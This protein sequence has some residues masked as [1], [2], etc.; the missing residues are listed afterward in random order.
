M[1]R[2]MSGATPAPRTCVAHEKRLRT[3]VAGVGGF[4][5]YLERFGGLRPLQKLLNAKDAKEEK[6]KDAKKSEESQAHPA[7]R[8]WYLHLFGEEVVEGFDGAEFVVADVEDGVELGNKEDV[9]DFLGKVEEFELAARVADGGEAADELSETGTVEV[10]DVSEVEDDFLL[11]LGDEFADSVA[12]R[13]DF[14]AQ[15]DAAV[16]VENGDVSDLAGVDGQGH[17]SAGGNGSGWEEASQWPAERES[18]LNFG[19][20]ATG[21]DEPESGE[22]TTRELPGCEEG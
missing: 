19:S 12:E 18:W 22:R 7:D 9:V 21:L 10:V 16:D 17:D 3:M 20:R 11:V 14:V 1:L 2:S 4:G 6:I 15:D 8:V 5:A 13:V